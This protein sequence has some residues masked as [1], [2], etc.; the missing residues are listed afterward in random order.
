MELAGTRPWNWL[1]LNGTG[2]NTALE[3]AETDW[4][5]QELDPGTGWI[6]LDLNLELT[7]T[8]WNWLELNLELTGTGWS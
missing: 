5:W 8:G 6:L 7:G 1:E 3:L 4:N 2:C